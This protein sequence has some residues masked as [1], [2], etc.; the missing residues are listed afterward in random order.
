MSISRLK[1]RPNA[2]HNK[3]KKTYANDILEH[4]RRKKPSHRNKELS[5]DFST[6][7][8]RTHTVIQPKI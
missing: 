1:H 2:Q 8:D 3:D 6:E 5:S 4:G 7:L